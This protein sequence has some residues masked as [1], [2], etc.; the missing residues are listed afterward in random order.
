MGQRAGGAFLM[1]TYLL[2]IICILHINNRHPFVTTTT[3]A[4]WGQC[5]SCP[6]NTIIIN[7][8]SE[9]MSEWVSEEQS[10]QY[11]KSAEYYLFLLK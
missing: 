10:G 9:W 6:L 4:H 2:T 5:L 1:I 8:A 11:R 7:T 3:S